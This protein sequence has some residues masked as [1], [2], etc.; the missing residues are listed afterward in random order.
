MRIRYAAA[1]SAAVVVLGGA[2]A[3]SAVGHVSTP[4]SA[5][6][7][8][9]VDLGDGAPRLLQRAIRTAHLRSFTAAFVLGD[10]CTPVWDDGVNTP[11]A[12]DAAVDRVISS[13]QRKG[14]KVVVSFGGA[15][16]TELALSCPTVRR[17]AEAYA[18]VIGR[19]ALTHVDFDIEG[20]QVSDHASIV[21]R[22]HAIHVL[23][24]R[25]HQLVVSLTIP[26]AVHGLRAVDDPG[27]LAVLRQAKAEHVRVDVVNL[28]TMDYGGRHE[29]GSAAITAVR[30]A[31]HQLRRIWPHAGYANLGITPMIGVNDIAIEHFTRADAKRVAAFAKRH[32]VGRTAFWALGRDKACARPRR[33]A[34]SSCSGVAQHPLAF[35]RAFLR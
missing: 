26:S 24:R 32:H 25:D 28:M 16:P 22:F 21:R 19:F 27:V 35:T 12:T 4:T 33:T 8:P 18:S 34:S 5:R 7:A 31:R 29:M 17:L 14:V 2:P 30:A 13:A 20:D 9:Y 1:V 15:A 10:G 3:A 11:V 23:E 6:F